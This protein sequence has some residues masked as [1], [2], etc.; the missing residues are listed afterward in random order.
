MATVASKAGLRGAIQRIKREFSIRSSAEN[1]QNLEF[2]EPNSP[3]SAQRRRIY[4]AVLSDPLFVGDIV[5]VDAI[6]NWLDEGVV[7][8]I[9]RRGSRIGPGLM[10][11]YFTVS[12]LGFS[13]LLS[14]AF[15]VGRSE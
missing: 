7:F 14:L 3:I 8:T 4:R 5:R 1:P 2:R 15:V 9:P 11:R 6:P 12:A 10:M 13:A